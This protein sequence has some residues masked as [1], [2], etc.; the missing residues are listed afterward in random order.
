MV[1]LEAGASAEI[2]VEVVQARSELA[3][4]EQELLGQGFEGQGLLTGERVFRGEDGDEGLPSEE[5][6]GELVDDVRIEGDPDFDRARSQRCEH[7]VGTH[8]LRH[9]LDLRAAARER[10]ANRR[11]SLELSAPRSQL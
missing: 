11:K 1:R 5:L 9:E 10:P 3:R 8:L 4:E 6:V 2:D 7:S